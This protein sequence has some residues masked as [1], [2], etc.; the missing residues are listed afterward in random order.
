MGDFDN[1]LKLKREHKQGKGEAEET[2]Q[3]ERL[4]TVL[5]R[6]ALRD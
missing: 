4:T 6:A 3:L 1:S 2:V 5:L